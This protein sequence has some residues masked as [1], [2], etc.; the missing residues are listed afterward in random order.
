MLLSLFYLKDC[1]ARFSKQK[2]VLTKELEKRSKSVENTDKQR[3]TSYS[4]DDVKE[5]IKQI[6]L[7]FVPPVYELTHLR[8]PFP[9]ITSA[10]NC[11]N[12]LKN[13]LNDI[14]D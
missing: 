1:L 5:A 13:S 9:S 2:T 7:E 11:M 6:W 14:K 3:K 12:L 8:N 4:F 10:N